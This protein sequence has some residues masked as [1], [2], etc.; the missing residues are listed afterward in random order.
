MELLFWNCQAFRGVGIGAWNTSSVEDM[1]WTFA[2]CLKF[3]GDISMWAKV[4]FLITVAFRA[5]SVDCE[6]ATRRTYSHTDSFNQDLRRWNM[7]VLTIKKKM[8]TGADA[9]NDAHLP[10][11]LRGDIAE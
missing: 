3:N 2:H 7:P 1:G 5:E 11:A 10:I 9:F 4:C 6:D 8:L